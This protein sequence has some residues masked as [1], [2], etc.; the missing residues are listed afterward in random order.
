MRIGV[1]GASNCILE[2]NFTQIL[3]QSA[4]VE[5]VDNLSLGGSTSVLLPYAHMRHDLSAYDLIIFD[6]M[7]NEYTVTK[8]GRYTLALGM[9]MLRTFIGDLH[10][11]GIPTIFTIMPHK[12]ALA[13]DEYDFLALYR[14]AAETMGCHVIDMTQAAMAAMLRGVSPDQLWR[15]ETHIS[16]ALQRVLARRVLSH[17]S[18]LKERAVFQAGAATREHASAKN[19][20]C[21]AAQLLPRGPDF[22]TIARHSSLCS[23]TYM[24]LPVNTP[25]AFHAPA[26][27][28]YGLAYNSIQF[29]GDVQIT[30]AHESADAVLYDVDVQTLTHKPGF[31]FRHRVIPFAPVRAPAGEAL[32]GEITL[33]PSEDCPAQAAEVECFF[34]GPLAALPVPNS[35]AY[36]QDAAELDLLMG[37]GQQSAA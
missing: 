33:T 15:D 5:A 18:V 11:Q 24:L 29:A 9:K 36:F 19:A 14:Q 26:G 22:Q 3:S 28:L 4:L 21:Q 6:V 7:I 12:Q 16:P 23:P 17:V 10:K 1:V 37:S 13:Q 35:E 20:L 27:A 31:D 2:G 34:G 25:I 32:W 8:N 30:S